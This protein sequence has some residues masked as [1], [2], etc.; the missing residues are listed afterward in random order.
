MG[1]QQFQ[2]KPV[3]VNSLPEFLTH[4]LSITF[5]SILIATWIVTYS[6]AGISINFWKLNIQ[7]QIIIV[8]SFHLKWLTTSV[9]HFQVENGF[10]MIHVFY[11]LNSMPMKY[12]T[13]FST[14]WQNI[15]LKS[16]LGKIHAMYEL[17]CILL[18][19]ICHRVFELKMSGLHFKELK[20]WMLNK[21]VKRLNQ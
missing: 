2:T 20:D 3:I 18:A 10:Y 5:H 12:Y 7:L 8:N 17:R 11:T 14:I 9:W 19:L 1:E 16:T 4:I 13:I 15:L 6:V 21:F